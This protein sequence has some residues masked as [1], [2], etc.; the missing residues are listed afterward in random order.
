M[1]STTV[2]QVEYK[3]MTPAAALEYVRSRRPRVLLAPSQWKVCP[4]LDYL[5]IFT[6]I[7]S[8]RPVTQYNNCCA[9]VVNDFFPSIQFL[10]NL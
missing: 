10:Y 2:F 4:V 3:H 6:H 1:G 9:F 5:F 7:L 8:G